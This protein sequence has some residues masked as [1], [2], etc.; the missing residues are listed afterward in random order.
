MN[1]WNDFWMAVAASA[2]T[3]TGLIFIGVSISLKELLANPQLPARAIQSLVL[4]MTVLVVS[5]LNLIPK[6]PS[7][8]IGIEVLIAGIIVWFFTLRTDLK[9]LPKTEGENRRY[10]RQNILL[11]Q[12]AIIP[13]IVA[14]IVICIIGKDGIYWIIPGIL[15]CFTKAI[16]DAWV[17]L[18]EIYR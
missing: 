16:L 12:L 13:Y 17:L 10:V 14:G 11:T 15:L 18:V 4:L 6:Q 1:E 2:A 9:I 3:L 5:T 7:I 8:L